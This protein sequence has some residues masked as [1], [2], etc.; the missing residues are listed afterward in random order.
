MTRARALG[1]DR[2]Q[3]N[4]APQKGVHNRK[5]LETGEEW[6]W[7]ELNKSAES[8]P[9]H[10]AKATGKQR[11]EVTA[12]HTGERGPGR[13]WP[14]EPTFLHVEIRMHVEDFACRDVQQGVAELHVAQH[15]GLWEE[16]RRD[17]LGLARGAG[18]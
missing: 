12:A 1:D 7:L 11:K 5:V 9:C 6:E 10:R 4:G 8:A 17:G 2:D 15:E 18:S 16:D 14:A 3:R 13:A